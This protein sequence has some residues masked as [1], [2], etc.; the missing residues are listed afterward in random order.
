MSR[1]GGVYCTNGTCLHDGLLETAIHFL[2][3]E[4]YEIEKTLFLSKIAEHSEQNLVIITAL[5][6]EGK[7]HDVL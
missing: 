6:D 4:Q 2:N 5:L 1:V 3:C 7:I